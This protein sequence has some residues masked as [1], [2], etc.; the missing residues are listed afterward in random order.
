MNSLILKTEM[1][2][3]VVCCKTVIIHLVIQLQSKN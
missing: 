1:T 3:S 2:V